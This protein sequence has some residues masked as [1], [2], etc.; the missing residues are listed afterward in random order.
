MQHTHHTPYLQTHMYKMV[1]L[2]FVFDASAA[3][4]AA[5]TMILSKMFVNIED[6]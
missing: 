1:F 5:L 2:P 6:S 4:A 3:A